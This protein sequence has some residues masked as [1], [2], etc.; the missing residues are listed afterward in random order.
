[1]VIVLVLSSKLKTNVRRRRLNLACKY[2][3]ANTLTAALA[4]WLINLENET[5]TSIE[6]KFLSLYLPGMARYSNNDKVILR[7]MTWRFA[8]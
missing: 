4:A 7:I 8:F 3:H 1:M 6:F 2:T 5:C